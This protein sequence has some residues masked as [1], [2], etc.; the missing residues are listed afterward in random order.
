MWVGCFPK[1]FDSM[2]TPNLI[3]QPP[4]LL[5]C[6]CT[7]ANMWTC[8]TLSWICFHSFL[9]SLLGLRREI[10]L[11]MWLLSDITWAPSFAPWSFPTMSSLHRLFPTAFGN[12]HLSLILKNCHLLLSCISAAPRYTWGSEAGIVFLLLVRPS[13]I[14]CSLATGPTLLLSLLS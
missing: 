10:P 2:E 5:L 12:D 3:Q 14:P 6:V 1:L 8:S 13:V 4:Y 11:H 7:A 9:H